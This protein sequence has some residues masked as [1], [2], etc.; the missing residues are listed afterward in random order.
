M[1]AVD[2]SDM[3]LRN[4]SSPREYWRETQRPFCNLVFLLPFLTLYELG[5]WTFADARGMTMRNGAEAWLRLWLGHA[6]PDLIWLPPLLLV[7][8]LLI[9]HW[10]T[11]QPWRLNLDTLGGMTAECLLYAF[12]LILLGQMTD[13]AFR[14]T[15]WVKL[16]LAER[17]IDYGSLPR[18]V[19]FVG[20]GIYEEFLF[21][22]CLLPAVYFSLRAIRAPKGLAMVGTVIL[23]SVIFSLAHYLAP[24]EDGQAIATMIDAMTRV[25]STRELWF[26][27]AF[28]TLA[29]L[30]FAGICLARGFGITVGTHAVYDVFV[31]VVLITEI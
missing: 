2:S 20:A 10:L 24:R 3:V 31:G 7:G 27:F 11:R 23:T 17:S 5:I 14:Q 26:G 9:W 12:M 19:T 22:L 28:R 21:R 30:A 4:Y 8:A 18:V 25:L 15:G 6:S 29:G 1:R 16:E 13:F